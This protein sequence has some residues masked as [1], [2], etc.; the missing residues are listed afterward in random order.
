M[1]IIDSI[2]KIFKR[3]AGEPQPESQPMPG[4]RYYGRANSRQAMSLSTVNR[5]VSLIADNASTLP[6]VVRTVDGREAVQHPVSYYFGVHHN[7][8]LM[9][10]AEIMRCML[11]D[12]MLKGNGYARIERDS[13][14]KFYALRYVEDCT[15]QYNKTTRVLSYRAGDKIVTPDD[16]LHFKINARDGVIGT[17]ILFWATNAVAIAQN[18][19]RS[20][21]DFF[22]NGCNLQGILT[23][24]GNIS[25]DQRKQIRESWSE[26]HGSGGSGLAVL[27]GN[28]GYQ[29]I[30]ASASEAQ[31]LES[32]NFNVQ[33]VA[34]FFGISPLLLG[35]LS[36]G[37][38][39]ATEQVQNQFVLH[40]LK[41]YIEMMERELSRKLLSDSER[42]FYIDLDETYLL[43]SDKTAMASYYGSMLQNGIMSINEVRHELGLQP[44][45]GL[46]KHIVAY[47]DIDQNTINKQAGEGR[48]DA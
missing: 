20:A 39:L 36:H 15:I 4:L 22:R 16:M 3:G 32:R 41:P 48:D 24:Q 43:K 40:T 44:V 47:T 19:D 12:A 13:K 35:D 1:N 18:T 9:A 30:Q 17:G 42:Q 14:G 31:L 37:N 38:I 7:R 8:G 26:V 28:M 45:D 25:A 5:A 33:E 2:K 34:R 46:D 23:V 6:V 10:P 27:P 11:V 29:S 21:L